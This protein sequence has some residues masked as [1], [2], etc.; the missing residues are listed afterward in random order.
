MLKDIFAEI[1]AVTAWQRRNEEAN[2]SASQFTPEQVTEMSIAS[3]LYPDIRA[4][5]LLALAKG[6]YRADHPLVQQVAE[7]SAKINM[8][9]HPNG[10]AYGSRAVTP[11]MNRSRS[12]LTGRA[13]EVEAGIVQ[14]GQG[15]SPGGWGAGDPELE[16][17]FQQL[18]EAGVVEQGMVVAPPDG[19]SEPQAFLV[20]DVRNRFAEKGIDLPFVSGAGEVTVRRRVG[21]DTRTLQQA[22]DERSA[23]YADASPEVQATQRRHASPFED[24]VLAAAPEQEDGGGGGPGLCDRANRALGRGTSNPQARH[25]AGVAE[26][27]ALKVPVRTAFQ[28]MDAPVQELQG[29]IRN[30]YAALH[31]QDVDW[32]EAQSD[33]LIQMNN[34]DLDAGSGY[35]TDPESELAAERRRREAERGQIGG[36]NVTAGRW[37]ADGLTPFDPDTKPYMVLSGLVDLGVQAADPTAFALGKAGKAR[38][39]RQLFSAADEA[40]GGVRGLRSVVKPVNAQRWLDSD[41]GINALNDLA[42]TRSPTEVWRAM[43]H[44]VNMDL[45]A[46]LADTRSVDEVRRV[47]EP[48]LGTS[49]REVSTVTMGAG[50]SAADPRKVMPIRG[51]I[52]AH[53]KDQV[54]FEIESFLHNAGMP[55]AG[56]APIIDRVARAQNPI[57]LNAAIRDGLRSTDG[58]LARA[59]IT[60]DALRSKL[61]RLHVD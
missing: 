10:Q 40:A 43:N 19:L 4:G 32:G 57:E 31:G 49:I 25:A 1:N 46:E 35:F 11:G 42:N 17:A 3:R 27:A 13:R 58:L 12:R 23:E 52:D 48:H 54:A 53:D 2:S 20:N 56:S 34:Q 60:D 18:R 26:T 33:L 50:R 8:R 15:G 39:A 37:A 30:V 28:A 47:L 44:K 59:G 16:K 5:S 22:R 21:G 51:R 55:E 9:A 61:T 36:H 24:V 7:I 45:A 38:Q 6:G 41:D 14:P 29:Q